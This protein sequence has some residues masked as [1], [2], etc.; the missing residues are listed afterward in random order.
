M[1]VCLVN[2]H[3]RIQEWLSYFY[4]FVFLVLIF[5]FVL[6]L[7]NHRSLFSE[8]LVGFASVEWSWENPARASP[9]VTEEKAHVQGVWSSPY[10]RCICLPVG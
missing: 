7:C 3:E 9:V 8:P 1:P 4:F 6:N 2:T 10:G 5:Y